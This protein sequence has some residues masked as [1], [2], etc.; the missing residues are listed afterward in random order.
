MSLG[1]VSAC[2]SAPALGW[3]EPRADVGRLHP[4]W[5]WVLKRL[6][7]GAWKRTALS[8]ADVNRSSSRGELVRETNHTFNTRAQG[9]RAA[10]HSGASGEDREQLHPKLFIKTCGNYS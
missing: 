4:D 10:L 9:E 1:R 6:L 5:T 7:T 3:K 8:P 2:P